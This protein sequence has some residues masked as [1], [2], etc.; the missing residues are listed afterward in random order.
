M[1]YIVN[2]DNAAKDKRGGTWQ[3][4]LIHKG[5]LETDQVCSVCWNDPGDVSRTQLAH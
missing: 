5:I 2:S 3:K 4:T 1:L